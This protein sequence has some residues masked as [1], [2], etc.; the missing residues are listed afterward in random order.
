MEAQGYRYF[1]S[2]LPKREGSVN[3]YK[4]AQY[5]VLVPLQDLDLCEILLPPA[6]QAVRM[7][8]GSILLLNVIVIPYQLAPSEAECYVLERQ[9][10]L[11]NALELVKKAGCRGNIMVRIAHSVSYAILQEAKANQVDLI[12]MASGDKQPLWKR[13]EYKRLQIVRSNLLI[14][15]N[16]IRPKINEIFIWIEEVESI[17]ALLDNA[18]YLLGNTR[19]SIHLLVD[20]DSMKNRQ[21][22]SDIQNYIIST[23]QRYPWFDGEIRIDQLGLEPYDNSYLRHF[24]DVDRGEIGVLLPYPV[25]NKSRAFHQLKRAV[26]ALK[27]PVYKAKF[28]NTE[29]TGIYWM[30]RQIKH[31]L[32]KLS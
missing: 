30:I 2:N 14:V 16:R 15:D 27:L 4:S 7:H 12:V 6:I 13:K 17:P 11:M 22:L 23:I 18:H 32:E 26:S 1:S 9:M 21:E 31:H 25:K 8:N 19:S 20:L 24:Y 5:M 29:P 28:S 3:S 10:L